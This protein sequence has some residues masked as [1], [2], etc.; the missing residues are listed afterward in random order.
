M[1]LFRKLSDNSN[2]NSLASHLRRRRFKLFLDML[3]SIERPLK[4]LDV[5]GTMGF[6]EQM[7]FLDEEGIEITVLNSAPSELEYQPPASGGTRFLS[8]TADARDLSQF[9]D[10]SF[11]VVFSNSVLEHVG[12]FHDQK[13]MIEE[14]SRVG[15][16][17]FVQTPNY[18]FPI[19]PH[20]HVFGFQFLPISLRTSLLQRFDLG[21][22]KKVPD[23]KLAEQ[24]VK[25]VQ[26]LTAKQIRSLCPEAEIHYERAMGLTKSFIICQGWEV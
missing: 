13:R 14:V 5:G 10:N 15:R 23:R 3:S 21:W 25:E 17:I 6:W 12:D 9:E 22:T 19:E 20:F 18:Y 1:S 8:C 4:I 24:V 16:R 7:D 2:P 11:D 26:L